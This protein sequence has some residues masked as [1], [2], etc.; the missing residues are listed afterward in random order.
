V[1]LKDVTG[2]H[3]KNLVEIANRHQKLIDIEKKIRQSKQEIINELHR[4]F[5]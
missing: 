2:I 3:A 1:L 4:R 5:K